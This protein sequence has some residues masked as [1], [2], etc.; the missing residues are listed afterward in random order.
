M[1]TKQ[2]IIK[3][4]KLAKLNPDEKELDELI[5]DMSEIIAFADTINRNVGEIDMRSAHANIAEWAD[6]R[7]DE[8]K[9]SFPNEEILQNVGGGTDGFYAVKRSNAK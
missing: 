7:E 5:S 2:E 8:P 3:L 6:L 1:V 9:Q 4:S